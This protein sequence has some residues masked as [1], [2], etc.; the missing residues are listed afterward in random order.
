MIG[1]PRRNRA[2]A[3]ARPL[4][5]E[6]PEPCPREQEAI[7]AAR[8][9]RAARSPRVTLAGEQKGEALHIHAPH[10]DD[11]GWN[12][13]LDEAF[14]TTSV[15]LAARS[16]DQLGNSLRSFQQPQTASDLNVGLAV[17]DGL[18]PENEIEA[19]LAIQM[20][21][22][23]D[24][25]IAMLARAKHDSL[26]E[27]A[28]GYGNLAAKLLRTFT[29]QAEALARLRRGGAQKV[30]VEH[31]H[32]HAGG[33]AIVGAVEAGGGVV[34]DNQ[35]QPHA[36]PLTHASQPALWS[37]DPEREPVPVAGDAER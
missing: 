16:L 17:V 14:G 36:K 33:Q 30:T 23:H 5:P 22:T 11:H 25:A 35:R 32:V 19:M 9:R 6:R 31:V 18:K 26:F 8:Q 3:K 2:T 21:V 29:A 27:R 28:S 37:A 20:A 15:S 24:A 12:T 7:N 4:P 10:R 34:P 13:R 1:Q